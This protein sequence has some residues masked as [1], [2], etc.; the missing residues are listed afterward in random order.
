MLGSPRRA[1]VLEEVSPPK[2]REQ[3]SAQVS[4]T[5]LRCQVLQRTSTLASRQSGAGRIVGLAC[6]PCVAGLASDCICHASLPRI[7]GW[8]CKLCCWL[9]HQVACLQWLAAAARAGPGGMPQAAQAQRGG[10]QQAFPRLH[11]G[12]G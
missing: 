9:Q 4:C 7:C 6:Q 8:C 3:D 11:Q 1:D 5:V 2:R 10:A 12:G